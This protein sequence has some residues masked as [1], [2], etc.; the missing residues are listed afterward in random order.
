MS[1]TLRFSPRA[2]QDIEDVLAY[3]AGQFGLRKYDEYRELIRQALADL[4]ADPS[5]P[6]A[7]CRPELQKEA[8]TFHIA[9][10][11]RRA[12]HFFIYRIVGSRYVDIGRLLHD[13]MDI[14]RHLPNEFEGAD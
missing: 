13:S 2:V 8:W 7:R 6:P 14:Q 5:R 9:R 1:F 3:T 10:R 11:G 4:A 12:R